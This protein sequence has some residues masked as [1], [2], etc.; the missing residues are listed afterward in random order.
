M[1]C[2]S[3]PGT[4]TTS[5]ATSSPTGDVAYSSTSF[6]VPFS[7][8]PAEILHHTP[9]ID[10]EH[11]VSWNSTASDFDNV[12]FLS[13]KNVYLPGSTTATPPPADYVSYLQS[14][15]SVGVTLSDQKKTTVGG[16]PS[17]E[18][19]VLSTVDHPGVLGCSFND[20]ADGNN[21]FGI[22]HD[23]QVR[24]NIVT[25]HG[26][27]LIIWMRTEKDNPTTKLLAEYDQMIDSVTFR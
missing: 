8:V 23:L 24:M 19:T 26:K 17:T 9:A 25:V 21:C 12:R 27:P 18:F 5:G 13:P 3:G 4:A 20:I 7:V 10:V 16:Q 14:M 22:F 15:A 11:M 6:D 2:T 1:G